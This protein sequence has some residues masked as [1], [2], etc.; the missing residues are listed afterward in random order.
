MPLKKRALCGLCSAGCWIEV[1]LDDHGKIASVSPDSD[2][3]YGMLC[4]IGEMSDKIV[5]SK[6]RLQYPMRR[7]GEKGTFKFERISWDEAY[8]MIVKRLYEVKAESGPE[9]LAVYTGSGSFELALCD[10]FQPAGVAVSS[11]SSVLFPFGCPNTLGVGALCYVS[12]AMIA[13]HVTMG[14]MLIDMFSDIENAELIVIWGKNPASHCP[15][16]DF[17]RIE[18]AHKRGSRIIVIDPRRTLFAKYPNAQWIPIRPGTDGALALSLC[19][20]MIEEEMTDEGFARNWT[21]GYD[22]FVRHVQHYRPEVTERITGIPAT[23]I[24]DLAR[25]IA[26]AKG[27]AP[28]M[29]S[30]LEYSDGAVQAIR[31]VFTAWALAGQLDRPGGYCF[32]MRQNRFPINKKGLVA[33]PDPRKAAGANDFP[34]YTK[35]RGE[36]HA[37]I[38]PRAVLE[39]RPYPIRLL[40]S[41]GASII[42][43]WPQ[44]DIWR[45]TL[46]ALDFLVCID[47]QLTADAAYAD[48]LLPAATYYEIESYMVYGSVFRIRERV[49]DPVGDARNDFFIMAELARRLGY[50]HLYPQ[51]EEELLTRALEGSGFTLEDVRRSGGSVRIP[52]V[53][54]EYRKWEKG[55]LRNDGRP[56]F[57]T[58]SGKFEIASS[59][60]EEHGYDPLPVYTEPGESPRSRPDLA[61][62][63]PLVF[64]SGA[65]TTIDLH[66]LNQSAP[67]LLKENPLPT[68]LINARDAEKRNI[69]NGDRINIKTQR[70]RISMY[71]AVTEDIVE[72]AVEA[73]GMGGSPLGN[74][75]WQNANINE[76]TDLARFDP[77][78]GFPVYKALLCEIEK[79]EGRSRKHL[80]RAKEYRPDH[81]VETSSRARLIY[82]DHNATSPLDPQV[83]DAMT[84]FFRCHGN[85]SSLY[86]LGVESKKALEGARR[87]LAL[88]INCTPRR[89]TFTS[90]GSEANNLAIKGAAF[91]VNH[92]PKRIVTSAIEHPSVINAMKQLERLGFDVVYLKPNR[93]GVIPVSDFKAALD[94]RTCMASIMMANNETGVIQPIAEF[95]GIASERGVIFH[96]DAVQATGKIPVDVKSLG[97]DLL[98]ISG[99]K[100]NGPKGTGA[101]Y[102]REGVFLEPLIAG[103]GQERGLRAGTENVPALVGLGKAAEKA[104]GNFGWM[105]QVQMLRDML[106]EGVLALISG[107]FRNGNGTG[108]L[109]NTASI[110]L[111]GIRGESLVMA[112]NRKG[113]A[114]SSGS[115]CHAGSP[116]PSHALLAMGLSVEEAHCTVRFSL[117]MGNTAE[118]VEAVLEAVEEAVVTQRPQI[119]FVSCR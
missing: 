74:R 19:Q 88:L 15:P 111:P 59:V 72:G 5:Y 43:S 2:S 110:T 46:A 61:E 50:G 118:E 53:M 36:F 14:G 81:R 42:N 96:S 115:A 62:K 6:N 85:P 52:E 94:C 101:L 24:V 93:S 38:L 108:R 63:F 4:R 68:V 103:G 49:I 56:G 77:I 107:S 27:A 104:S 78:S 60:L 22:D 70:G 117:G 76:L 89:I 32:Q 99:H 95:A 58:P 40:I 82:M 35:Y 83:I 30:G 48:I 109:P 106:E 16:V 10:F 73:S 102:V 113:I 47:R 45:K 33:N 69:T 55:L 28:V 8:E 18:K 97:V 64:N 114:L 39:G 98:T 20:V 13:P 105:E 25:S 41:L 26:G 79:G 100:F 112:L 1:D 65:R 57:E 12:F 21:A 9:S 66:G 34:V 80:K 7:I 75:A 51:N 87:S 23:D 44:S 11:A 119:R 3:P 67:E 91:A 54:M 86:D 31:A 29:Y 116:D 90:G 37:G 71:A 92:C 17:A 84:G